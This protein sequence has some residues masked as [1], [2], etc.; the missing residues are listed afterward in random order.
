MVNKK[1]LRAIKINL[2]ISVNVLI[3]LIFFNFYGLYSNQ[4]HFKNAVNFIFPIITLVHFVYLYVLWF[5]ISENE[6]PDVIMK[7]LEYVMYGV[8]VVYFYE[9]FETGLLLSSFTKFE[10]HIIPSTFLPMGILIL[11]LQVFLAICTIWAFFIRK[12]IIGNYNFDYLNNH[13]DSHS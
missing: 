10:G 12:R 13:I 9:I 5:K 4:F 1:N 8:L 6:Y 3:V 7:N 11:G 2:T